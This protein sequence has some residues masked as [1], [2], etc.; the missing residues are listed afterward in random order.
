MQLKNCPTCSTYTLKE[1]CKTCKTPTAETTYKY[2]ELKDA[3]KDSAEFFTV[4]RAKQEKK[5]QVNNS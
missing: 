4:K 2:K 3:P 5:R 1:K